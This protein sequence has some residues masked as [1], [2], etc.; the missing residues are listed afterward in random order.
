MFECCKE[1]I[2]LSQRTDL[3]IKSSFKNYVKGVIIKIQSLYKLIKPSFKTEFFV[4]YLK[5]SSCILKDLLSKKKDIVLYESLKSILLNKT[6]IRRSLKECMNRTNKE[7][8]NK[9]KKL[10]KN[11]KNIKKYQNQ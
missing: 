11:I 1:F 8:S 9:Y 7:Y 5:I 10:S 4:Y 3:L 2:I 6:F